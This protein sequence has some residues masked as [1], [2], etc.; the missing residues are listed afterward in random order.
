M[1]MRFVLPSLLSTANLLLINLERVNPIPVNASYTYRI[2]Y[3]FPSFF[4]ALG[5]RSSLLRDISVRRIAQF[6]VDQL[7]ERSPKAP[8]RRTFAVNFCTF[9]ARDHSSISRGIEIRRIVKRSSLA[10]GVSHSTNPFGR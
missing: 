4:G 1:E 7:N 6:E 10:T 9:S 5:M 8:P 3:T 2:T